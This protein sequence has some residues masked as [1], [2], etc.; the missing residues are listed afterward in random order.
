MTEQPK[1][2]AVQARGLC[3]LIVSAM[4]Q[5]QAREIYRDTPGI[6]KNGESQGFYFLPPEKESITEESTTVIFLGLSTGWLGCRTLL[7]MQTVMDALPDMIQEVS[8]S[9]KVNN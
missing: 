7:S 5:D 8:D 6:G 4:D 9:P 2:W 1:I 3:F